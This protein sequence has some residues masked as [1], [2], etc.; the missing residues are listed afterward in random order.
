MSAYAARH[1]LRMLKEHPSFN[2]HAVPSVRDALQAQ[3]DR[4]DPSAVPDFPAYRAVTDSGFAQ[5]GSP[6]YEEEEVLARAFTERVIAHR[7]F[8]HGTSPASGSSAIDLA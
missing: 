7:A 3:A 6:F 5:L 2:I 4:F 1:A 8:L